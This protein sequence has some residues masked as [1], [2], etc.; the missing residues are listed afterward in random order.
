MGCYIR[1][2]CFD[3]LQYPHSSSKPLPS[4]HTGPLTK[5]SY[6]L[7]ILL[8]LGLK[9]SS[10][11]NGARYMGP[12]Y[13]D[14]LSSGH[15]PQPLYLPIVHTSGQDNPPHVFRTAMLVCSSG[16]S[17]GCRMNQIRKGHWSF[18]SLDSPPYISR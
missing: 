4:Q 16:S 3:V 12:V 7:Q 6:C 13:L 17:R 18:L 1:E 15:Y 11:H 5:L 2:N 14:W 10:C 8:H 9:E